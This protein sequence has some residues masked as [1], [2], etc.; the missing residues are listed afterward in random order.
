MSLF[1]KLFGGRGSA[2]TAEPETY[3]DFRIFPEPAKEAGGF[4]IGARIEKEL[5]GDVKTHVMIRSD[6]YSNSELA[7]AASISKAKQ[8]IDQQGEA[9]FSQPR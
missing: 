2:A 4:R 7:A 3:Q 9:I 6:T 5:D 8:L 1:S